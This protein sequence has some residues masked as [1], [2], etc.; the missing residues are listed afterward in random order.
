MRQLLLW[1]RLIASGVRE[2]VFGIRCSR[3]GTEARLP[4]P[5]GWGWGT[6]WNGSA[7]WTCGDCRAGDRD[8]PS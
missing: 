3:C 8:V 7:A 2:H 4:A 1:L 5:R 6:I